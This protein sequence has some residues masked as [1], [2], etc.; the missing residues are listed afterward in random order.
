MTRDP[1]L[2]LALIVA[3]TLY[4]VGLAVVERVFGSWW[5]A[6]AVIVGIVGGAA[7]TVVVEPTPEGEPRWRRF[8]QPREGTRGFERIE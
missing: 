7:L 1:F 4:V 5:A 2:R 8:R 6:A 3:V